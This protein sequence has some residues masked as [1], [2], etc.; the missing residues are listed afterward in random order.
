MRYTSL[1]DFEKAFADNQSSLILNA[2]LALSVLL[3]GITWSLG[4]TRKRAE[5]IANRMTE[6]LQ[7]KDQAIG[8][9][10]DGVIIVDANTPDYPIIYL[11]DAF[12]KIT[13]YSREEV[14]GRNC[15]FLQGSDRDQPELEIIRA[16]LRE[17]TGCRC[18]LRNYRKDGT[19]F[20]NQ[21]AIS[22]IH[23]TA[24]KLMYFVGT[25][26]D[27]TLRKN[28]EDN[29]AAS[30]VKYRRVVD[31]VQEVIFQTDVRGNWTFINPAWHALTGYRVEESLG[32]NFL[33]QIHPLDRTKT[34][35][36]FRS[37][38]NATGQSFRVE[39][40]LMSKDGMYRWVDINLQKAGDG[41]NPSSW[42]SGTIVDI[43][44]RKRAEEAIAMAR[45]AAVQNAR[46]KAD[47][48]ANMS[49]EIRT[50]L[51]GIVGMT[52][53][54]AETELKPEQ[55]EYVHTIRSCA[56]SLLTIINDI[57]DFSKI[58]AGKLSFESLDFHLRNTVEEAMDMLSSAAAAKSLELACFVHDRVPAGL[59]GDPG[60]LK[61]ILVNLI[62]N[63]IKFTQR[64]EVV[65]HVSLEKE[66]PGSVI[67]KFEVMDTGI[68]IPP[69]KL[70][71]LFQPFTQADNST[72]RKYGGTGLGLSISKQLASL[73]GGQMGVES[74]SG[75]GSTFWFTAEFGLSESIVSEYPWDKE[76]LKGKKVLIVD[77]NATNLQILAHELHSWKMI[78]TSLDEPA[79]VLAQ[80]KHA[81]H[82]GESFD[83]L[84]LDMQMPGM[85]GLDV[86]RAIQT[87]GDFKGLP[88]L[89]MTS[90]TH[91]QSDTDS[92]RA[93]GI[94]RCLTKPVKHSL[95]GETLWDLL[96]PAS[97]QTVN[98]PGKTTETAE[99]KPYRILLAEDNM[100]NQK[101]ALRQ[102]SRLGYTEADTVANGA[103]A[104]DALRQVPY[105]IVL[106]DC[107]MPEMDGYE[108]A[109]MIRSN[110]KNRHVVIIAMT[111]NAMEE[112]KKRCLA[113]GMDDYLS[114]PVEMDKLRDM[115]EKWTRQITL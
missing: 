10:N 71:N 86:A 69:E 67:I 18:V 101:V 20:Y 55:R 16:A 81:K 17:K 34:S 93:L 110:E 84:I 36:S 66:K 72:T 115:L 59:R 87:D 44:E 99:K 85:D 48:L 60:R 61:Q 41:I 39:T 15:R 5:E 11:N 114:K 14:I 107:Q 35:E 50:P 49:H 51:N 104:V 38:L 111:A 53:L 37:V 95:L 33:R 54:I 8:S 9:V 100:I 79:K 31:S 57:L 108:A 103:E 82:L 52:G 106:M 4:T 42:I 27:I 91:V 98:V 92:Q 26:Q 46:M 21:L 80:I 22:P 78:T 97:A 90:G 29:L 43:T 45:D 30:E 3:F 94:R 96:K 47:F 62:N 112:D 64:G 63:A 25:A 24:G 89:L 6:E 75:K 40:R 65:I 2:G 73:M 109:A 68:G 13:G 83:I 88:M 28:A 12:V 56:D 70:K 76:I 1:P 113:A 102:L 74:Q 19:L 58:E 77:D 32:K 23:S 7:I 105:H